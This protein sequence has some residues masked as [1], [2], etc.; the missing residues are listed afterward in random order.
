METALESEQGPVPAVA[1]IR[2]VM[3][4]IT[5][6]QIQLSV[7]VQERGEYGLSR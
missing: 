6:V 4:V 7:D 3:R 1:A 2:S 5:V